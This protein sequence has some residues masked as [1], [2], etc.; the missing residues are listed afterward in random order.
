MIKKRA[1]RIKQVRDETELSL[2]LDKFRKMQKDLA[3]ENKVYSKIMSDTSAVSV[4][5]LKADMQFIQ[6]DTSKFENSKRWYKA[7]SK[8]IYLEETIHVVN[9]LIEN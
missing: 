2:N 3:N 5:P 6:N 1:K 9:D 7:L 8:D 4:I